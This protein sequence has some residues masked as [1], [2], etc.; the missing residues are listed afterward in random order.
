MLKKAY[1]TCLDDL[2][3]IKKK[4][5]ALE[6][7]NIRIKEAKGLSLVADQAATNTVLAVF[8]LIEKGYYIEAQQKG[9]SKYPF[10]QD[11]IEYTSLKRIASCVVNH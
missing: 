10:I 6:S 2:K 1:T 4:M 11:L 5:K 3:T 7:E 9:Q 8:E